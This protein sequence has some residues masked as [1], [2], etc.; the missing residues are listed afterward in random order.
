MKTLKHICL[1]LLGI[2]LFSEYLYQS[3]EPVTVI[4][5]VNAIWILYVI[6]KHNDR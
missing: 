5:I 2:T 6:A 3:H 4:L 1:A